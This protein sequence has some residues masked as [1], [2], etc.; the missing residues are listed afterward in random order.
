[1]LSPLND[2]LPAAPDSEAVGRL[3]QV[4][5]ELVA[6]VEQLSEEAVSRDSAPI[7]AEVDWQRL[8]LDDACDAGQAAADLQRLAAGLAREEEAA[9]GLVGR[10][11]TFRAS[12]AEDLPLLLKEIGEAYYRWSARLEREPVELRDALVRRL[13]DA[14][15]RVG[16]KHR[17]ELVIPGDRF[18]R[19][20]HQ[21][22]A[23]GW[24][25]TTVC[26]WVVLR[27]NGS[28]YTKAGVVAR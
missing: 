12:A 7:R 8:L 4:C 11:L 15:V 26:G 3:R 6:V 23:G 24:E 21:A 28:V 13:T 10:L 18:D 27:E 25:V 9:L 2:N 17:I 20:R 5:R 19:N 22:L 16:L 1:M 14:C